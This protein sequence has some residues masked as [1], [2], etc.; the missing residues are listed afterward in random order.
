M[1]QFMMHV[2]KHF[3]PLMATWS[4]C[5]LRVMVQ[6]ILH[7][8]ATQVY[9]FF[10]LSIFGKMVGMRNYFYIFT[11]PF[12]KKYFFFLVVRFLVSNLVLHSAPFS[13]F[14]VLRALF[15]ALFSLIFEV[16][17]GLKKIYYALNPYFNKFLD[18]TNL[19]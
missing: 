4:A 5:I 11:C 14:L 16:F 6:N 13:A 2:G 12:W 7:T 19:D 15:S 9:T 18:I 8:F 17:V 1:S 3:F 10:L